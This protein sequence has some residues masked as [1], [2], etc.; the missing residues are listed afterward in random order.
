MLV[1]GLAV[2]LRVPDALTVIKYI[3]EV[4]VSP[5]EEVWFTSFLVS[6]SLWW[7]CCLLRKLDLF[8]TLMSTV[9]SNGSFVCIVAGSFWEDSEMS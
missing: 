1:Q 6:Y 8:L 2:S 4:G 5:G 3:C 9:L 7:H